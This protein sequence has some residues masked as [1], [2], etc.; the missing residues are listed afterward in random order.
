MFKKLVG[1]DVENLDIYNFDEIFKYV[2]IV[3]NVEY[4][5]ESTKKY[6]VTLFKKCEVSDFTNNGIV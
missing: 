5:Q 2:D 1:E 6:F 3:T 4:I